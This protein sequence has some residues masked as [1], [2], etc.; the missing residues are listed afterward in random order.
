MAFL[1]SPQLFFGKAKT[2][3]GMNDQKERILRK[4]IHLSRHCTTFSIYLK[5]M[6]T[7]SSDATSQEN[8]SLYISHMVMVLGFGI[9][10]NAS[11]WILLE[12]LPLVA[13]VTVIQNSSMPSNSK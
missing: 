3:K 8:N 11:C 4:R 7:T 2:K 1:S 10:T 6:V 13:L 12:V 9:R 5:E